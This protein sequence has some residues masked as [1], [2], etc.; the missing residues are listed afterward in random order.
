M[1][2]GNLPIMDPSKSVSEYLRASPVDA[3]SPPAY[4]YD[5]PGSQL[6]DCFFPVTTTLLH[7][8]GAHSSVVAQIIKELDAPIEMIVLSP[9]DLRGKS[10]RKINPAGTVPVLILPNDRAFTEAG[11]IITHLLENYDVPHYRLTPDPRLDPDARGAYH[12]LFFYALSYVL[13]LCTYRLQKITSTSVSSA[14][15]ASRERFKELWLEEVGP[16]LEAQLEDSHGLVEKSRLSAVDFLVLA[17]VNDL[18]LL[19]EGL[20]D[21]FPNLNRWYQ[22]LTGRESFQDAYFTASFSSINATI[23]P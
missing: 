6:L 7:V 14:S 19:N 9:D 2:A 20:L 12:Q 16:Y 18:M 21:N 10:F 13:P 8:N 1:E 15:S 4:T 22:V 5:T 17:G 11:A 23:A 3:I